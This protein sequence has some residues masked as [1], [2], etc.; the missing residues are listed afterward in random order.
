VECSSSGSRP[1]A[2]CSPA[3]GCSRNGRV[4]LSACSL[5]LEH[6]SQA[7]KPCGSQSYRTDAEEVSPRGMLHHR[8]SFALSVIIFTLM[9][10]KMDR[11]AITETIRCLKAVRFFLMQGRCQTQ[12]AHQTGPSTQTRLMVCPYIDSVSASQS[13]ANPALLHLNKTLAIIPLSS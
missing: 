9:F 12:S 8:S 6:C 2:A 1:E 5:F 11:S 13:N 7:S 10:A 4:P 3:R